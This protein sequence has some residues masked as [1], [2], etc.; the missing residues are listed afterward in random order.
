MRR[1]LSLSI[2]ALALLASLAVAEP[3][4]IVTYRSGVPLVQLSGYYPG[5]SYTVYRAAAGEAE[6]RPITESG[7][8]CTGECLLLDYDARPGQAYF[9]R[10]DLVIQ[11]RFESFGPYAVTISRELARPLSAVVSPNP[12]QGAARVLLTLPGA[13]GDPPVAI[14]AAL[15]DL[16][17]RALRTLHRGMLARGTTTLEWDGRDAQGRVL[18]PGLYFLRL[19]SASG[20]FSTPVLRTR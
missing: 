11:G 16:E 6:F 9:Y 7:V 15:F 17:G 1:S 14:E 4:L 13:P 12:G 5:S 3:E 8:L 10:F 20:H 19:R 2:V 18:A